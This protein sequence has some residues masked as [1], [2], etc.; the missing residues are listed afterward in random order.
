MPFEP[1]SQVEVEDFLSSLVDSV[2]AHPKLAINLDFIKISR[3]ALAAAQAKLRPV[4]GSPQIVV[5]KEPFDYT[6]VTQSV[7]ALRDSLPN[8]AE[9]QSTLQNLTVDP[10]KIIDLTNEHRS[11]IERLHAEHTAEVDQIK[12]DLETTQTLANELA[13]LN[14]ELRQEI[15]SNTEKLPVLQVEIEAAKKHLQGLKG[16]ALAMQ[17]SAKSSTYTDKRN[18]NKPYPCCPVCQGINPDGLKA[19]ADVGH[20]KGCKM[21]ALCEMVSQ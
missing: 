12:S 1:M 21:A 8:I 4:M 16:V 14:T 13:A 20:K 19:H 5:E 7:N 17:W 18:N 11:E 6:V 15:L 10:Q 3:L 2:T 9:I